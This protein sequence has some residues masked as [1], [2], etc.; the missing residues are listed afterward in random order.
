M[1]TRVV[2]GLVMISVIWGTTWLAIKIGLDSIPPFLAATM[3]FVLAALVLG[4]LVRLRNVPF[5]RDRRFLRL[6]IPLGLFSFSVPFA[7]VYWGQQYIESGL[8]SILFATFPLWV[9][10]FSHFFLPAEHVN[11][12]KW[13]GS[14]LGFIGIYVIFASEITIQGEYVFLGMGAIV[15]S[16][17]LQAFMTVATKKYGQDYP[18]MV[19]AFSG[20]MI[21]GV[22]MGIFSLLVEDYSGARFDEKAILSTLYL[23]LFGS[24]MTFATYYWLLKRVEAVLLSLIAF[25]TPIIAIIS[26]AV[27]LAERLPPEIFA[28]S[29]LVLLGI[30]SANS[31][32][33][34]NVLRRGKAILLDSP[35]KSPH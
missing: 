13:V 16:A 8:A 6:I 1:K 19:I 9:A 29:S 31:R 20:M 23:A 10:V 27:L 25:V 24:V 5:P 3:R 12:M 11:L 2:S 26:G 30:L 15:L 34:L 7:L 33:A 17:F 22:T 18:A 4:T 14:G 35:D 28:G 21:G 32:E